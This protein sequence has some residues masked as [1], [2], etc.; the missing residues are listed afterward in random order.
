MKAGLCWKCFAA[1][2]HGANHPNWKGGRIVTR[3]Y[4]L[5]HRPDHPAAN[6][7]GYVLEH[8][9]V[10]ETHNGQVLP[11]GWIIH[12]LNGLKGDNRAENLVALPRQLHSLVLAAKAARIRQLEAALISSSA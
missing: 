2:E 5:L 12:H 3:G 11:H 6:R 1:Q 8:R 10:W 9:L 7:D 4:I